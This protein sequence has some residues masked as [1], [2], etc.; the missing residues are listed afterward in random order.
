[1][2]YKL[3]EKIKEIIKE[4]Y[5]FLITLLVILIICTF[6]FPYYIEAPGGIININDRI[7]IKD[8]HKSKGTLNMA[9]VS[10][11]KATVPTIIISK[12]NKNWN[13][14][15]RNINDSNQTSEADYFRNRILL[16]E[17]NQ[18][19]VLVAYNSAGF[20]VLLDNTKV[21]VTYVL[22]EAD[23]DLKIGDQ[24]IEIN[25]QKINSKSDIKTIIN[26]TPIDNTLNIKVINDEKEYSRTAKLIKYNDTYLLGITIGEIGDIRTN[27]QIE[28]NFSES[29]MGP[30]GGLMMS[31][32]IYDALTEDDLTKGY[33]IVGTGTIDADGNVGSI[34]GVEYKIK[35]AV[36]E[37]ADIFL[38]PSGENY[39]EAKKVIIDNDYTIDLVPIDTFSEALEY[40]KSNYYELH[41]LE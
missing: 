36:K 13:I 10:E 24:I 20:D 27:P 29:E 15:K 39:E 11:Y 4:N 17:A 16:K 28:F 33:K 26:N 40:L 31:L 23:T 41:P 18:S 3:Y 19:A 12:F 6:E 22:Q 9:Y 5:K 35:G 2:L 14:I 25:N 38:V 1:M 32:A 21:Y 7:E 34:D 30:S 8:S 37:D